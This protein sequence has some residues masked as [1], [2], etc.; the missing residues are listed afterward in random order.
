MQSLPMSTHTNAFS[1]STMAQIWSNRRCTILPLSE[2]HLLNKLW[3]LISS[4]LPYRCLTIARKGFIRAERNI[5]AERSTICCDPYY[6]PES[7]I[8][9]F[10]ASA[11]QRDVFP[12]P[13]GPWSST[14]LDSLFK[15]N[16][17]LRCRYIALSGNRCK[18]GFFTYSKI[19]D[20]G[21][22]F[23]SRTTLWYGRIPATWF[24][25]GRHRL[26]CTRK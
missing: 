11:R 7:R 5:R 25:S 15:V 10:W 1:S 26:D 24:G 22:R 21:S 17:T 6:I 2:N 9:S 12:V 4:S 23:C 18:S 19:W 3:L 16:N 20:Q 8:D 14:T 13:G